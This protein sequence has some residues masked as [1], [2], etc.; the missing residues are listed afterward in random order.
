MIGGV[1]LWGMKRL[2]PALPISGTGPHGERQF[3]ATLNVVVQAEDAGHAEQIVRT[4]F[5][6]ALHHPG[7]VGYDLLGVVRPP[8]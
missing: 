3:V 7:H 5:E 8:G 6:A 4:V 1:K 2:P